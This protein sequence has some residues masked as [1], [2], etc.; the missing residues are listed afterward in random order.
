MKDPKDIVDNYLKAT[1]EERRR[2]SPIT[3]TWDEF[4]SNIDKK[5]LNILKENNDR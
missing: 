2:A 5:I 4:L 3:C 1:E